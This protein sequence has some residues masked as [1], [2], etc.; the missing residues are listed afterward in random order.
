MFSLWVSSSFGAALNNK[1]CSLIKLDLTD[2]TPDGNKTP[3]CINE[4]QWISHLITQ[5]A[6]EQK[7]VNINPYGLCSFPLARKTIAED[8]CFVESFELYLLQ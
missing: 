1:V 2:C 4:C 7:Q 3:Y 8:L 6:R 5:M